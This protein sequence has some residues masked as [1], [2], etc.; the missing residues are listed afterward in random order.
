MARHTVKVVANASPK[1][2]NTG[3]GPIIVQIKGKV[4]ANSEVVALL[5]KHFNVPPTRV[6][7]VGGQVT[8]QKTVEVS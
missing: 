5:A 1:V 2:I 8:A 4:E 6:R 3:S 7:V